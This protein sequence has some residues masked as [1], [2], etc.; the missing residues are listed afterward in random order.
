MANTVEYKFCP[1]CGTA[2]EVLFKFGAERSVCP[3]CNFIHFADPKVV[4]VVLVEHDRKI[5]LGK[6]SIN[7]GKGLWS[8][9]S[10]FVNR[11]ENVED[12]ARREVKEETNLDVSLVSLLGVFS[13]EGNPIIRVVFGAQINNDLKEMQPQL[14]EV[15]ELAFFAPGHFPEMAFPFDDKI[16]VRWATRADLIRLGE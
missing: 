4:A 15:S 1:L 12:A 6:R 3:K 8:F 14:E 10:G 7:P 13:E 5:L 2:L 9:P 16:L 11:G